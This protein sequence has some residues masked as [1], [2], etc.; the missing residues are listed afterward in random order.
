MADVIFDIPP[1]AL[2]WQTHAYAVST[3]APVVDRSAVPAKLDTLQ[4]KW[5][6]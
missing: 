4:L 1:S 3:P 2:V 6:L 5:M